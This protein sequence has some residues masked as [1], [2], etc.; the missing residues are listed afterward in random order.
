MRRRHL[1][2]LIFALPAFLL[3]LIGGAMLLGAATGVLWLFVFGDN[4]WPSAANTLLTTTFIIGTLALWLAQLA[5]AYAI[6]KT[7]ERRPSL[8]RTHVAASVGATIALA[9]LIAVRVLGIGSAA[10]RTDTMIC[11]DHCLA[12][13]FSASGMAPR[14]SGDHTCTCYDAQGQESVS[15][16]IER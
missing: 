16:P 10:A 4:P 8:N 5:I 1:Y 9:G 15:V 12:R 2:V 6:G 11:A 13:G 7:Q 3:S 14:D